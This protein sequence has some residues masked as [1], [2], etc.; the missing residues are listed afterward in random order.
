MEQICTREIFAKLVFLAKTFAGTD[1]LP[2]TG[3]LEYGSQN[4]LYYA[5]Q[6]G[7]WRARQRKW[8]ARQPLLGADSTHVTW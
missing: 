8:R 3:L 6:W 1:L 5:L 7:K 4:Q 2:G